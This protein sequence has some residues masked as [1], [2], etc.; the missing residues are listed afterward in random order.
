MQGPNYCW[1]VDGLDKLKT[2]GFAI[3]GCIDGYG[4]VIVSN[5]VMIQVSRNILWLQVATTNNDSAVIAGY[6][7][8]AFSICYFS[9]ISTLGLL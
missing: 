8:K 1:H 5:G 6:F 9:I 2:Y 3:H 7:L 4:T